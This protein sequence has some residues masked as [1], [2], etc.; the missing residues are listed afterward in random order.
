[1][2]WDTIGT[3]LYMKAGS[4]T[5]VFAATLLASVSLAGAQ[6]PPPKPPPPTT[7]QLPPAP[8]ALSGPDP[9]AAFRPGP[10]DLYQSPDGSDRFQ[11]Q[12][13]YPAPPPVVFVPGGYW[14]GP[15]YYPGSYYYGMQTGETAVWQPRHP[16]L[17]RGALVLQTIPDMAQVFVDGYY[18]GLAEEF[19]LRGRPMDVSAGVHSIEV[20]AAGYET[21]AFS[22]M[23][24]PNDIV[25]YRGDMQPLST[26]QLVVM[27]PSPPAAPRSFYVIPNCYAGDKPP[28]GSLP[29]GCDR[30]NLQ[31]R[32]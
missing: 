28:T 13:R 11:H 1:M 20:R 27:M 9:L 5:V 31:T 21:L 22:I 10:R 12:S 23:I 25:R 24:Q 3:S 14:P 17:P 30:K 7:V 32:R 29:K 26:K 2:T 8:A 6:Q 18:V 16:V 19:G 15:Y 4:F